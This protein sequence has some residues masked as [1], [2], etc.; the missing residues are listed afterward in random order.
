MSNLG[1]QG[2][3]SLRPRQPVQVPAC[4]ECGR[5]DETL[6]VVAYPF[7]VSLVLVTFRRNF[8]G[9]WCGVHRP[10]HLADIQAIAARHPDLDKDRIRHWVEQFG[11]ALDSPDL[12]EQISR[13][14]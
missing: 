1:V 4:Q 3:D 7:V 10:K 13:W 6:R 14:L 5:Q 8:A 2:N 9:V 11:E 12:W